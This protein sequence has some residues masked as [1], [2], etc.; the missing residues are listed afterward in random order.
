MTDSA[1]PFAAVFV[2]LPTFFKEDGQLDLAA[3]R[4]ITDYVVTREAQGLA[5]LFEASEDPLLSDDERRILIDTVADACADRAPMVINV[6]APATRPAVDLVKHAESKGATGVVVGPYRLP[7]L[8]YRALYRHFDRLAK[9]SGSMRTYLGLRPESAVDMLAPEE[10]ATLGGHENVGGIYAPAASMSALKDWAKRLKSRQGALFT[11]CS[12]AFSDPAR[13]GATATICGLSVLGIEKSVA[14]STA[15]RAGDVDVIRRLERQLV[16]AVEVLGPP[17]TADELGGVKR[18]AARIAQRPLEGAI[19]PPVT[20]FAMVKEGLRLQ[21][22]PVRSL[23]RP[24]Y[25]RV[26]P[27]QSE[28]LRALMKSAGLLS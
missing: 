9:T 24:P 13:A 28:R 8:G 4:H 15:F 3:V 12:F 10:L 21:G 23:V 19:L 11:G 6:S 5:V 7:G 1:A 2:A 14:L 17:K 18:L 25:E 26:G 20:P 22:H 27:S 16:P